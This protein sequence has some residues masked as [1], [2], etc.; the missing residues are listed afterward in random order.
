MRISNFING[1]QTMACSIRHLAPAWLLLLVCSP[2]WA[3]L[4]QQANDEPV[5]SPQNPIPVESQVPVDI[6][7][8]EFLGQWETDDGQ[9]IAPE[10]L[11]DENFAALIAD[12]VQM[13]DEASE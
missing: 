11:A 1:L 13:E 4:V 9:W 8:L 3:G 5:E 7:F 2:L 10:D 6:G 12:M